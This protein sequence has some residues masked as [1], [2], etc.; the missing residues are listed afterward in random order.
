MKVKELI[1]ELSNYNLE[2]DVD[3]VAHC[4]GWKDYTIAYGTSDGCTKANC[5]T[6][7]LYIDELQTQ[8][9]EKLV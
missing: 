9:M 3:I 8:E 6:V 1:R 2:A 4:R 7:S 5:D